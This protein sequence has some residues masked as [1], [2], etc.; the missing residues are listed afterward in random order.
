MSQI[1]VRF[2]EFLVIMTRSLFTSLLLQVTFAQ[3]SY[4]LII[5]L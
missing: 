1:S 5:I 3:F 4:L 2:I